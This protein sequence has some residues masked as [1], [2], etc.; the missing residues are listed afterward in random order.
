M[1][2][3]CLINPQHCLNLENIEMTPDAG[4]FKYVQPVLTW[5]P[6][7]SPWVRHEGTALARPCF[8]VFPVA[9]CVIMS[10]SILG[11]P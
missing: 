9:C 3:K 10:D 2:F 6:S 11:V 1:F 4:P 5:S 8:R 7:S